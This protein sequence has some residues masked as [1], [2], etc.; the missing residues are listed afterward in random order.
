ME[1]TLRKIAESTEVSHGSTM[2]MK[3]HR[4]CNKT[5]DIQ[6]QCESS[7]TLCIRVLASTVTQR[8]IDRI[9]VFINKCLRRIVN[10]GLQY[11]GQTESATRS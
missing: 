6:L 8:V 11:T 9:Q 3:D 5:K 2:E 1:P 4:K 10:V 7:L